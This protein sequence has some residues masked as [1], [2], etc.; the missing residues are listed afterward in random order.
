MKDFIRAY[1]V[2]LDFHNPQFVDDILTGI[3]SFYTRNHMLPSRSEIALAYTITPAHCPLRIF[4]VCWTL[5]H[6]HHDHID[7]TTLPT[8]PTL[9]A[10]FAAD[11]AAETAARTASM[12]ADLA[13]TASP[14]P[15]YATH[16]RLYADEMF[17]GDTPLGGSATPTA[18][19]YGDDICRFHTAHPYAG[20]KAPLANSDPADPRDP[21]VR[22]FGYSTKLLGELASTK[23]T[24]ATS[25]A[26]TGYVN[27]ANDILALADQTANPCHALLRKRN[28]YGAIIVGYIPRAPAPVVVAAPPLLANT[29][30][31]AAALAVHNVRVRDFG[32]VASTASAESPYTSPTSPRFTAAFPAPQQQLLGVR[33]G[34]V[35]AFNA[36]GL[37][38]G[39]QQRRCADGRAY[40]VRF[41]GV[42]DAVVGEG[43]RREVT[44]VDPR[45]GGVVWR[46]EDQEVVE[47]EGSETE[48]DEE[49]GGVEVGGGGE[50]EDGDEKI[51]DEKVDDG[52]IDD[53]KVDGKKVDGEKADDEKVNGGDEEKA[54]AE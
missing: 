4:L 46:R 1:K 40:F 26:A 16:P 51:G 2:G 28:C 31:T 34:V 22:L 30:A 54:D 5:T 39:W 21:A 20:Y 6:H 45:A 50:E 11:L 29:P 47:V 12:T 33:S 9:R 49:D 35:K 19:Y 3:V 15:P 13:S 25:S 52:K 37:P 53:E 23:H 10:E 36:L 27:P 8:S 17:S 32:V 43:G 7:P 18:P 48:A 14:F 24:A 38:R 42:A 41:F 44:W